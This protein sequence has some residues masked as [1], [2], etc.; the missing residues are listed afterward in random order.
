[1]SVLGADGSHACLCTCCGCILTQRKCRVWLARMN[2][3]AIWSFCQ[4]LHLQ[5]VLVVVWLQRPSLGGCACITAG[6]LGA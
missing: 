1:M 4:C 6:E 3:P 5:H 2:M